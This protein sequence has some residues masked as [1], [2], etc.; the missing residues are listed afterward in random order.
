[1]SKARISII[2][3][4]VS[5]AFP[6][7]LRSQANL[8]PEVA[9]QGYADQIVFNGKIV[10]MDDAGS[11]EN[12]GN[13]YQAMAIKG[14]RIMAL[15]TNDRIRA[16]AN[17]DT[18]LIDL[19]GQTV[20][21]GIVETHVHLFGGGAVGSEMG[22][23]YPDKGVQIH[24]EAGKDLEATRLKLENAV[25]EAASKLQPG[26]WVVAN[27]VGNPK[28]DVSTIRVED[29][30]AKG[31]MESAKRLDVVA[32]ENPVFITGG[33]R[34][35][36]N[37][38]GLGVMRSVFPDYDKY[39][40]Q[41][42]SPDANITGDVTP[43]EFASIQWMVFYRNQP[44]T[45]L[46]EMLRRDLE[47]AAAH[48]VTTFGSRLDTSRIVSAYALLGR[49]KQ[50]PIRFGM[51]WEIHV[52][53]DDPSVVR[54]FYT[55]T[56]NLTGMGND[57]FWMGGVASERWDTSFPMSCL[58]ADAPAPANI[59]AKELCLKPGDIYWDTL[60]NAVLAGWRLSGIHG[61]GSDGVRRFLRMIDDA[62]K[63]G[64]ISVDDIRKR[65]FTIEHADVLGKKPDVVAGLK[66]YG[67]IVSVN[68]WRLARY[69]DFAK[70]YGPEIEHM[71]VPVKSLIDQGVRVVGQIEAYQGYG[72]YWNVL[73]TRNVNGRVV[74]PEEAVGRVTVMKMWTKWASEYMMK[75]NDLGS[76]EPG[77]FADFVVL[78]KDYF[79]IPMEA[80]RDI[81][82]Q[83]TFVGGKA[84]HLDKQYAAK[85]GT[86]PVGYQFRDDY[87]PWGE[88][89][90][91][92]P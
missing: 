43:L 76:L 31:K 67:I 78:D 20:I 63:M 14:T 40:V 71:M 61:I 68:P 4:S 41:G 47:R 12:P 58:G 77:K 88:S 59:K 19:A 8:P 73:M 38:K 23:P 62:V 26:E 55:K 65:R 7:F 51:L 17:A 2:I 3:F 42:A 36:L 24:L 48:G 72:T 53:P 18:K 25:K 66:K 57:Y 81:R 54:R 92:N 30:I 50:M 82:P 33:I 16:M 87:R 10:S 80:I 74:G 28:E 6:H 89:A 69:P 11:N 70:D 39:I 84:I 45:L 9:R 83:A 49:E 86:Q 35:N 85:L 56:G 60:Q 64:P 32:P 34:G 37:S 79:T 44:I 90:R 15:G 46:A 21:P 5:I 22:I 1:M 91:M 27:V 29:W 75:E 13:I 52:E